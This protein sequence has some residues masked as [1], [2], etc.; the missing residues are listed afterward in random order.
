MLKYLPYL[1]YL[2]VNAGLMVTKRY[3]GY[4]G[5]RVDPYMG[6]NFVVE[7]GGLPLG[8]FSSVSGL[9]ATIGNGLE[10]QEGGAS[11]PYP[12]G[13]SV[14]YSSLVLSKGVADIGVLWQ[15]FAGAKR[16][17]IHRRTVSVVLLDSRQT[18]VIAWLCQGAFPTKW[19]GPSFDASQDAVAVE[20][21][22]LSYQNLRL[23]PL[24]LLA[25]MARTSLRLTSVL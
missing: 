1:H 2:P 8:G 12:L 4:S 17:L 9:D 3:S 24:S 15:W 18:P 7:A 20:R 10:Y 21:I 5:R 22:E 16:G 19:V 11:E 25:G 23:F 6:F 14:S 13:T